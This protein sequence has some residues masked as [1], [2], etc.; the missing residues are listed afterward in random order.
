MIV[1]LKLSWRN[2]WRNKRRSL[3]VITSIGIGI[4]AMLV[5]MAIMNGMNYQMIDNTISTSLGHV[6]IHKKGFLDNMKA[7]YGFRPDKG[8]YEKIEGTDGVTGWAPRV[9]V[10]GIVRSSEASQGVMITGI[11]PAREKGVSDIYSYTSVEEGSAFLDDP[12]AGDVLISEQLAEKLDL[13]VGDR[14]VI[15]LQD[16]K[17]EIV[18]DALTVR[19]VFR[20]PI[21]SF[22]KYVIFTGIKRLQNLAG[23]K[24]LVSEISVRT[25]SRDSSIDVKVYLDR[26]IEGP[27]VIV[28][29]WQEMAPSIMSAVRLFDAMMFIFFGIVFITVIFSVANTMVMA[30][31]ERFHEIGVMKC[32][33]TRP[34]NIFIMILFEAIDLGLAGMAAGVISGVAVNLILAVTGLDLSIFS[35]SMRVWGTGSVIYP[36]IMIKDIAASVVVV[37]LTAVFAAIYPAIKAARIKP[38]EALNF[39]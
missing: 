35:E 36:L 15:M 10:Q 8:I 1:F 23:M 27:D 25:D 24:N 28:Q 20:S 7:S 13:L 18:G 6:S 32:I 34:L 3:V 33:G 12:A 37:V 17:D 9:K 31:M 4:F 38:L 11:D 16:S 30:V 39:I 5:I 22:D 29:S 14:L 19:G 26:F 21:D 2:V